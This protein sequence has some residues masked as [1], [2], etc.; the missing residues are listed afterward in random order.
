MDA[1]SKL[2][3]DAE[4]SEETMNRFMIH[5]TGLNDNQMYDA[6]NNNRHV[7]GIDLVSLCLIHSIRYTPGKLFDLYARAILFPLKSENG[8]FVHAMFFRHT[9]TIASWEQKFHM[10]D[11]DR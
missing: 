11:I 4:I 3:L 5:A 7:Q 10:A 9:N 6:V 8:S 2:S 1:E